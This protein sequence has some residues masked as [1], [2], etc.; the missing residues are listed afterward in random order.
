MSRVEEIRRREEQNYDRWEKVV[1]LIDQFIDMM[2]NYRQSGHP[3]GSRSKVHTFVSML[4][5][6]VMRWD[7]RRPERRFADRFVLVAGHTAPLVY[8][9]LPVLNEALRVKHRQTG[10]PRYA[11]RDEKHRALYWEHLLNFRRR[12]GLAGHAEMEGNTLFFKFNTGPSGHGSPPAA[13]EAVALKRAGAGEVRVFAME[14]EGGLTAGAGHETKNSAWGLGLDNLVYLVDWNDFGIDDH[15]ASSVVPGTPEDWF[16]SYGW[17]VLGTENGSE[18]P[19]VHPLLVEAVHGDSGGVP[20]VFWFKTRKG[21]GYLKYDYKSH[22][23]PHKANSELY[24]ETKRLFAEKYGVDFAGFGEPP[25]EDAGAFRAQ[26][27]TNFRKVVEVLHRD[28]DLV[29]YL[30]D[31]LVRIGDS[32]PEKIEGFRLDGRKSPVRDETITDFRGYPPSI[33]AEPGEKR[34]NRAALAKWGSWVNS[35]SREKYGRPLFLA[36]SA[37]LAASTNIAGFA[38]GFEERE[39]WGK[40]HRT[41]NPEGAL[42]PQEITEFTNSGITVGIATVNLSEKPE[43]EFEGFYAACSTYGS[44]SYLKYGPMRLFSQLAQDCPLKVGKVL[45][46][47]GHSGPETA[48]D[49]RTHFGVYAP[50]VT[51]LFPDGHVCDVHPWEYNEVPVVIAAGLASPA[52]IVALHLTRPGI[53]IPDRAAIGCAHHYEASR[54]AYLIRDYDPKRPPMGCILVQGTSTTANVVKILPEL[55]KSGLNVKLVAAIS[56]QLFGWQDRQYR[57]RIL[58]A[59]DRLDATFIS[60]RSRRLMFDWM[61]HPVANEYAMTSDFDNRWRTGGN[62]D[63]VIEEAHLSPDWLLTGI[64]RFVRERPERLARLREILEA[65]E[66]R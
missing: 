8:A 5:G 46:V 12:G 61:L 63:E 64:E 2:L 51:Q 52:P 7:A 59:E 50:G 57:D 49:S 32:V 41:E 21:R 15:P 47:A 29:D 33:W 28:Q 34:P 42:L 56:P 48:D 36:M 23:A 13:G 31:T 39:G 44:F 16:S 25:P 26:V 17:R 60:N 54:G 58:P 6:D 3:G 65:T 27:E 55:D 24:W 40:Y 38:D 1:D 45:W 30:A 14:G 11:I 35:Y 10:D 62:V 4:L 19:H 22:G 66:N 9:T 37:D 20:T 53:E 43:K 18:I